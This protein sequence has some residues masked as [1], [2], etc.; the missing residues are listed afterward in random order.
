V[1]GRPTCARHPGGAG[2]PRRAGLGSRARGAAGVK[3]PA[4][5]AAARRGW[6]WGAGRAGAGGGVVAGRCMIK[7]A[8]LRCGRGG[9]LARGIRGAVCLCLSVFPGQPGCRVVVGERSPGAS[10][11]P[12]GR[13]RALARGIIGAGC[14]W[15]TGFPGQHGCCVHVGKRLPGASRVLCARGRA[16]VRVIRGDPGPRGPATADRAC[17]AVA[18]QAPLPAGGSPKA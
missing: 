13:G 7:R 16:F 9:A 3:W 8:M 15:V 14:S 5:T 17:A 10:R 1:V 11:V 4:P 18:G 12:G 2:R 6:R